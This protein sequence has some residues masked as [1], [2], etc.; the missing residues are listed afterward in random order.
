LLGGLVLDRDD[1]IT[2]GLQFTAAWHETYAY[3]ATRIGPEVFR[4]L[5]ATCATFTYDDEPSEYG[6]CSSSLRKRDIVKPQP[7]K[8]GSKEQAFRP[9]QR[10]L[11]LGPD[12]E[13]TTTL[14]QPSGAAITPTSCVI[15]DSFSEQA[16]LYA[17]SGYFVDISP[18]NLRP[19]VMESYYYA[20]RITGD[21]MYQ[22]RAWDA[23]VAINT[24]SHTSARFSAF[25]GVN[26]PDGSAEY[27]DRQESFLFTELMK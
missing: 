16:E 1:H 23:F 7:T 5:R 10:W 4:W 6:N 22:D 24:T 8:V 21:T 25:T 18:Y 9:G 17:S 20:Y 19:E 13:P 15:P 11:D 12:N 27:L 3:S 26:E 2:A 14:T